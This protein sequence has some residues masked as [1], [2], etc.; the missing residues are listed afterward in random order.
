MRELYE[1]IERNP[2]GCFL[3][4]I[5]ILGTIER[6]VFYL[7]RSKKNDNKSKDKSRESGKG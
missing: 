7:S 4:G 1:F 6:V 3:L 5:A 2:M